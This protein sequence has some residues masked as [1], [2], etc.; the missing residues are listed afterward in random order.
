MAAS[1]TA[2]A[3]L[4]ATE[5]ISLKYS[6]YYYELLTYSGNPHFLFAFP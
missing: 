5:H 1:K 4:D 3:F 6:R 2:E